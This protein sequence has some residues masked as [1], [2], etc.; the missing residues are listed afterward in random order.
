MAKQGGVFYGWVIVAA[1]FVALR[2]SFG[3][4][5][6]FGA[7]FTPSAREFDANRAAAAGLFSVAVALILFLPKPAQTTPHVHRI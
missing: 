3:A 1:C 4:I 7:F 6:A 5:Y 2:L